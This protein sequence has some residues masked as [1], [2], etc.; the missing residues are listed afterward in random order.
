MPV[1][2]GSMVE[3]SAPGPNSLPGKEIVV[4]SVLVVA[5][6]LVC[7]ALTPAFAH[8]WY[9]LGWSGPI[10]G[11]GTT[12]DHPENLCNNFASYA[13]IVA[14]TQTFGIPLQ[15]WRID[16]WNSGGL[17]TSYLTNNT[18]TPGWIVVI[19]VTG[20]TWSFQPIPGAYEGIICQMFNPGSAGGIA[21]VSWGASRY[22]YQAV[23]NGSYGGSLCY[24][25]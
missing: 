5:F 3:R 10:S 19:G 7:V 13:C 8:S 20:L 11:G 15:R 16:V 2:I 24:A 12:S 9:P 6:V 1:A 22:Y 25:P 18:N 14:G 21:S 17:N 4:K 23:F